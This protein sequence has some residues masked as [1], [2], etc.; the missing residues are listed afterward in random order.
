MD[1]DRD[2]K[3]I[4]VEKGMI[5]Y[6]DTQVVI[7]DK[8]LL[9]RIERLLDLA[10]QLFLESK[11]LEA[12]KICHEALNIKNDCDR[13]YYLMAR[14]YSRKYNNLSLSLSLSAAEKPYYGRIDSHYELGLIAKLERKKSI[15]YCEKAI[16]INSD[17]SMFY[18]AYLNFLLG[19]DTD[20]IDICSL[21]IS[22]KPNFDEA[23]RLRANS[24]CHLKA[25]EG[26]RADFNC[27][28]DINP[29]NLEA[30]SDRGYLNY[31]TNKLNEAA[32]DYIKAINIS[33]DFNM[34]V[35]NREIIL[36]KIEDE[37]E[38]AIIHYTRMITQNHEDANA[39]YQRARY[40]YKYYHDFNGG[41][42]DC[43]R[44]IEI[45]PRFAEAFF[46]R[47]E[48][49]RDRASGWQVWD[50]KRAVENYTEAIQDYFKTIEIDSSFILAYKTR[51]LARIH[52]GDYIGAIEDCSL[53]IEYLGDTKV[54][55]IRGYAKACLGDYKGAFE[56]S[57]KAIALNPN[58]LDGYRCKGMIKYKLN[59]LQGALEAFEGANEGY[60]FLSKHLIKIMLIKS[61]TASES[62][63]EIKIEKEMDDYRNENG[64][65]WA[66]MDSLEI[67]DDLLFSNVLLADYHSQVN[68]NKS[69][70]VKK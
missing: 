68:D 64:E 37:F 4:K 18:K 29:R 13:A 5:N 9:M 43:S 25:Y 50:T 53:I 28:L 34:A 32:H 41:I 8:L 11:Y 36:V 22:R 1:T 24:K 59:D 20:V 54:Y 15:E 62:E 14:A 57:S 46:L 2:K 38:Y 49:K 19:K 27:V 33:S 45:N 63:K 51:S 48:I 12:I 26:A 30:Y 10:Y 35:K 23:Y 58:D 65:L 56:D 55:S 44:A 39:Y 21:L 69:E 60:D 40:K 17:D 7:T 3:L 42:Q 47:G 67:N 6:V 16:A 61:S 70:G 52:I 66:Y 31:V